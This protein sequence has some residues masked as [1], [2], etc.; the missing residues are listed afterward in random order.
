M[1]I[2]CTTATSEASRYCFCPFSPPLP[3]SSA[4][5]LEVGCWFWWVRERRKQ[6]QQQQKTKK[7][8][9][10]PHRPCRHTNHYC[11]SLRCAHSPRYELVVREKLENRLFAALILPCTA[12]SA[13]SEV[14]GASTSAIGSPVAGLSTMND[15]AVVAEVTP[16]CEPRSKP[17]WMSG[18][19]SV[20]GQV[21]TLIR[22]VFD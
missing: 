12:E 14:A 2:Q 17:P 19:R 1:K 18:A 20:A 13:R 11:A 16:M 6:I 21:G 15:P 4:V 5:R 7:Q 3:T 8:Q 22:N 10:H 9:Q